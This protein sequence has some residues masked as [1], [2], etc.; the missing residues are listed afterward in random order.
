MSNPQPEDKCRDEKQSQRQRLLG[1][2]RSLPPATWQTHSQALCHH[3][4]ATVRYQQAK[5]VLAFVS[6]NQEPDL[7]HLWLEGQ[8]KRWGLPRCVGKALDWRAW[9]PGQ[10][11][12]PGAFGIP[13]PAPMAAPI[14][15]GEA[16]LILVPAVG[17]D[18]QGNRLGYGGGFYDRLLSRDDFKAIPTIG[19]VFDV[20][21]VAQLPQ[22][23]WDCRLGGIC[24]ER[25]YF[26]CGQRLG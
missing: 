11:L 5:T 20:A 22:D 19:I 21:L 3:L 16:D 14:E 1:L 6:V 4:A 25:G 23:S 10:A 24:T 2:R 9:Q 12:V 26:D 15:P 18:R 13:E 17:C 8:D 7:S